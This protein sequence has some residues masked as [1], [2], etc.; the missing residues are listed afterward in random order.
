MITVYANGRPSDTKK[1]YPFLPGDDGYAFSSP[2]GRFPANPF[3]LFDMS[4][5]VGEWCRDWHDERY[6]AGSPTDDPQGS[7]AGSNR[8]RRGGG[9]AYTPAKCRSSQRD[10]LAP[11]DRELDL[12][13]RVVLAP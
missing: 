8:V 10:W 12:G 7:A 11:S 4:G 13:F 5:N 6:Y 3:G 9:F 1:P 2:V